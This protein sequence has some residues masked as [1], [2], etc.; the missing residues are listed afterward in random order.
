MIRVT[1][2]DRQEIALNCDW[3]E[4]IEA[5]PDTTIRLRGGQSLVV[6]ETIDELIERVADWRAEVLDRAGIGALL[7]AGP[8]PTMDQLAEDMIELFDELGQVELSEEQA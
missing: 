5:R 1:R 8:R 3:I 6:R 4:S 2:L 7:G